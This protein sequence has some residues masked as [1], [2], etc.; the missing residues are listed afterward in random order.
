MDLRRV[1]RVVAGGKRFRFRVTLVIGDENGKVGVGVAKGLDVRSAIEKAK[2]DAKKNLITIPLKDRTIPHEVRA[3]F[4]AADVLIKPAVKGHGLK[5]GGAVRVV[6]SLAG[7]KDVTAKCLGRTPNKLTN[8]FATI[9]ALK[10]L[11]VLK[12]RIS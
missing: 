10:Q 4:S 3:K 7:V 12:E 11:K 5:A 8:A 6:L 2:S 1:T 9:K